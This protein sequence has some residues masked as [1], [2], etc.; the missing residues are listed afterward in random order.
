[1]YFGIDDAF[2]V[3]MDC[4]FSFR[5]FLTLICLIDSSLPEILHFF[6]GGGKV[7][8]NGGIAL[9]G[10]GD[11]ME[12]MS[13]KLCV[14]YTFFVWNISYIKSEL[15]QVEVECSYW[16]FASLS[17]WTDKLTTPS[18]RF[19]V[20]L[21]S[22]LSCEWTILPLMQDISFPGMCI[23]NVFVPY[24]SSFYPVSVPIKCKNFKIK[25]WSLRVSQKF[26]SKFSYTVYCHIL[27]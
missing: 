9:I 11:N 7:E 6:G 24:K 13:S 3:H 21:W 19:S 12:L 2:T 20:H 4:S 10:K 8:K 22:A 14:L 17:W 16:S 23:L 18:S 25:P 1:M 27:L 26:L 15:L 5:L